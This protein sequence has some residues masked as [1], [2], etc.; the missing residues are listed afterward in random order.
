MVNPGQ[1]PRG[2][3][4]HVLQSRIAIGSGGLT[5]KGFL[6]GTQSRLRFLPARHT[7]FIFAVLGEE[8]GFAGVFVVLA[9]Y[10]AMLARMFTVG[11][12][13]RGTGPGFISLSWPP[14]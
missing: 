6:K 10:F 12:T 7:D 5:G 14:R 9:A 8:F 2:A 13:D 11:R 1:D 3:G 4:Y